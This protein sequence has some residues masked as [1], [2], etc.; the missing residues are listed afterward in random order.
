MGSLISL[1][2]FILSYVLKKLSGK[3]IVYK[4][5]IQMEIVRN[6]TTQHQHQHVRNRIVRKR[7]KK[8]VASCNNTHTHTY[9]YS[10]TLTSYRKQAFISIQCYV[11]TAKRSIAYS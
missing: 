11:V 5:Q 4:N 7:P 2:A 3:N 10:R 8:K 1:F 9:T 6:G